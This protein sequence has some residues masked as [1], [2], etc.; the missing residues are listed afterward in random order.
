MLHI[1][2]PVIQAPAWYEFD[3]HRLELIKL[4]PPYVEVLG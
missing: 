1:Q 2:I 4:L 3:K